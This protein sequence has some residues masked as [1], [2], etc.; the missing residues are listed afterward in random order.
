MCMW[1]C[2]H[3]SVYVLHVYDMCMC[4]VMLC[5]RVCIVWCL[6]SPA[7]SGTTENGCASWV[8]NSGL[9]DLQAFMF[10][11]VVIPAFR[12]WNLC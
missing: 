10:Q 11:A 8:E 5:S 2:V 7:S 9:I 4:V 3:V 1:L 12:L 6:L